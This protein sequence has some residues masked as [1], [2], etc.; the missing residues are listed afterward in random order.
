[1]RRL[2]AA[3]VVALLALIWLELGGAARVER[4]L[5]KP[6]EEERPMPGQRGG[7][8]DLREEQIRKDALA[9]PWK[10]ASAASR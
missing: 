4:L 8:L 2:F 10:P 9:V 6:A 7:I 1:M 3:A 5:A